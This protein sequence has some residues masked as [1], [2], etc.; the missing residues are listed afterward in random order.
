MSVVTINHNY[1][2][3]C[4][5][6]NNMRCNNNYKIICVKER[7]FFFVG[8]VPAVY[9]TSV[10][11]YRYTLVFYS[12]STAMCQ[13]TALGP[14]S[15]FL[16]IYIMIYNTCINVLCKTTI[17]TSCISTVGNIALCVGHVRTNIIFYEFF[18]ASLQ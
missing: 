10:I 3:G 6:F 15:D 5:Y 16:Y 14:T 2:Y 7:N 18:A 9:S 4:H 1:I 17:N 11:T 13:A 12:K 8:K